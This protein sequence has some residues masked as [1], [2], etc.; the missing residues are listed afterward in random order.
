MIHM[1]HTVT[2]T[3]EIDSEEYDNDTQTPE[4]AI[5][6]AKKIV[7]G[8]YYP[9]EEVTFVCEGITKTSKELEP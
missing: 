4:G 3:I 8:D 2:I 9:P 6:A 7:D 1:K 5:L